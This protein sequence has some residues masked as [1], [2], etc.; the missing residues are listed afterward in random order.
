MMPDDASMKRLRTGLNLARANRCHLA[1]SKCQGSHSM[2]DAYKTSA[3]LAIPYSNPI[4][5]LL[6]SYFDR[7]S[8]LFG[9]VVSSNTILLRSYSDPTLE[10][11]ECNTLIKFLSE[12][13][14]RFD[15]REHSSVGL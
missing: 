7:M 6:R 11:H 9:N 4:P 1:A 12:S 15:S 5:F 13:G 8:I 3:F 10:L 14:K 2:R